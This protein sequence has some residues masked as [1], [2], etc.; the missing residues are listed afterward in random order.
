MALPF[1]GKSVRWP[2]NSHQNISMQL[3]TVELKV[4]GED[5]KGFRPITIVPE[6]VFS[7]IPVTG[8]MVPGTWIFNTKR[9]SLTARIYDSPALVN[10]S[11]L[12]RGT[13]GRER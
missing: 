11:G 7:L 6:N 9:T 2:R 13:L 3:D 1:M 8:Y 12:P 4:G 5:L 10:S